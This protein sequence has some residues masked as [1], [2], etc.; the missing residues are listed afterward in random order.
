MK[1]FPS[2]PPPP[3]PG[4][5]PPSSSP[6]PLSPP[7]TDPAAEGRRGHRVQGRKGLFRQYRRG[8]RDPDR[9]GGDFRA[10]RAAGAESVGNP[11]RAG[12]YR[13][14]RADAGAADAARGRIAGVAG[15]GGGADLGLLG[16]DRIDRGR[17]GRGAVFDHRAQRVRPGRHG[18]GAR[19]HQA[20]DRPDRADQDH[21]HRRG[22][23]AGAADRLHHR[24]QQ[25]AR[26]GVRRRGGCRAGCW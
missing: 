2:L 1:H 7:T 4:P 24:A 12:R 21:R 26:P 16:G 3:R 23:R 6:P 15:A 8:V 20:C 5:P 13:H 17:Q 25:P 11:G 18:A 19:H 9:A 22:R 10:A 14:R